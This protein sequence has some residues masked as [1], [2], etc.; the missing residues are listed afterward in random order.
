MALPDLNPQGLLPE[1]V[2]PATE[3]D[4]KSRFVNPF[5]FN[6]TRQ[7]IHQSLCRYRAE[8]AAIGVHA[9]QWVD[10]SFVDSARLD[11]ED[12]DVVNYCESSALNAVT[13]TLQ[14]RIQQLLNGRDSTK[15]EYDTHTFLVIR[16]PAGHPFAARFEERRKY[17]RDW[18][19]RPQ[20]YSGPKK[21]PAP[22]RGRKGIVQMNVGDVN[23]C[24]TVSDAA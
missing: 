24:P 19:S 2:H 18:F 10:G 12:V 1:G 3:E 20:D 4:L 11:P 23:L 17:W 6:T 14:R 5:A 21:L 15:T 8:I 13:S 22:W 16:F 7:R 9:T